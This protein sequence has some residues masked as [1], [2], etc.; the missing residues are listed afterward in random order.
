VACP[1]EHH[2][3][4]GHMF[5][6]LREQHYVQRRKER[7]KKPNGHIKNFVFFPKKDQ[8]KVVE[9]RV[10][11]MLLRGIQWYYKLMY[12]YSKAPEIAMWQ[13]AWKLEVKRGSGF[14]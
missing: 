13:R 12:M 5:A 3:S 4:F 6:L 9:T 10:L 14:L 2:L 11:E 8:F 1:E 7:I